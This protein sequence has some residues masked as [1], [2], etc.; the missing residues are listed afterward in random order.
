MGQGRPGIQ[1]SLSPSLRPPIMTGASYFSIY[2]APGRT[3]PSARRKAARRSPNFP[4]ANPSLAAR[5]KQTPR[6]LEGFPPGLQ[7]PRATPPSTHQGPPND[8]GRFF[9]KKTR[10]RFGAPLGRCQNAVLLA[11]T[12]GLMCAQKKKNRPLFSCGRSPRKPPFISADRVD[13]RAHRQGHIFEAMLEGWKAR[14][15]CAIAVDQRLPQPPEPRRCPRSRE[16]A[17]GR[18][19]NER[20]VQGVLPGLYCR[21]IVKIKRPFPAGAPLPRSRAAKSF[22][23]S[24][25]RQVARTSL[26]RPARVSGRRGCAQRP[27]PRTPPPDLGDPQ[28]PVHATKLI[29][30]SLWMTTRA[31]DGQN[32][33]GN[34]AGS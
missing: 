14:A 6:N 15:F 3:P 22:A 12:S 10:L 27:G 28:G 7:A 8:G 30:K 19:K 31:A 32:L 4:P 25:I 9:R 13:C 5:P 24:W 17:V 21:P 26:T 2:I 33:G 18:P 34:D 20:L 11:L 23:A 16:G 29:E 1:A